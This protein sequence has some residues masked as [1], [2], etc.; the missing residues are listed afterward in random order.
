MTRAYATG[1]PPQYT[2]QLG[3]E[4]LHGAF[5]QRCGGRGGAAPCVV[6]MIP[7]GEQDFALAMKRAR[8]LGARVGFVC[9]TGAQALTVLERAQRALPK[10]RPINIERATARGWALT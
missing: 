10:H 9:D 7:E 4:E 1:I 5:L 2:K 6:L 3:C 8:Q